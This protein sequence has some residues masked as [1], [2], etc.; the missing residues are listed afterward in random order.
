MQY[1]CDP[2]DTFTPSMLEEAARRFTGGHDV[3]TLCAALVA[4]SGITLR[5]TG[6][7]QIAEVRF[8]EI[9]PFPILGLA[10]HKPTLSLWRRGSGGLLVFN[11]R[12]HLYQGYSPAQ[13]AA[14]PR[15]A[16]LL[17]APVYI[18][19]NA[20]GTMD[21]AVRP[22]SLVMIRDHI[23]LQGGNALA[24]EWGRWRLP[25]FPDMTH[26]YDPELLALAARHAAAVGFEV[27]QGVYAAVLG[28]SYETPAEIEMLRRVGGTVVG[29][30]TVQEV[31]AA[32]HL[33]LRVLVMSLA[34][35]FAAGM[36]SSPLTHEEVLEAG[37]AAKSALAAL[38]E[39]ILDELGGSAA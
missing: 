14:L 4:G 2:M 22:G 11:G 32:R 23:N 19:T 13:V 16:C 35:N 34:T 38:L 25:M 15:L 21:P 17:G 8:P 9:F 27:H 10:G 20:V 30:S 28:P 5:P 33:G 31:I 3:G 39:R 24:G 6:W 29:M 37:E 36:T 7:E 12:F 18:A 26:A 1:A